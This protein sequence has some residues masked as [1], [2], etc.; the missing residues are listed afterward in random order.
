MI[1][2]TTEYCLSCRNGVEH[3]ICYAFNLS[4]Y[5]IVTGCEAL[6]FVVLACLQLYIRYSTIISEKFE[7]WLRGCKGDLPGFEA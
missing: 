2:Y 3:L 5:I 1:F 4:P 7:Q 6:I